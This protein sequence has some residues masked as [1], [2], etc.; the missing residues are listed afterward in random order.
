M[1]GDEDL[2]DE[3]DDPEQAREDQRRAAG[4]QAQ[5]LAHR[6]KIGGDVYCVGHQQRSHQQIQH[7]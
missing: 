3:A 4:D 6:G 5:G 1:I 7:V 2:G